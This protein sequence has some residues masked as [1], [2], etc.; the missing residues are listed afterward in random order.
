MLVGIYRLI[1]LLKAPVLKSWGYSYAE[2]CWLTS[3]IPVPADLLWMSVHHLY[4]DNQSHICKSIVL[5]NRY[6]AAFWTMR[7]NGSRAKAQ[8][9]CWSEDQHPWSM[10][11]GT[12]ALAELGSVQCLF[13]QAGATGM[14]SSGDHFFSPLYSNFT[15]TTNLD[16]HT[17]L[18]AW[19]T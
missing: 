19:F 10:I 7:K 11:C 18:A 8:K 4:Y 13:I 1:Q 14:I 9:C 3:D 16:S 2:F 15:Q 5:Q 6:R 12:Q 17:R